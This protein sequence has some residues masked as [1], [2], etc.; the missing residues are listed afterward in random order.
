MKKIKVILL[1]TINNQ[2]TF[3][4]KAVKTMTYKLYKCIKLK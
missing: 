2:N 4:A 3:V 1:E